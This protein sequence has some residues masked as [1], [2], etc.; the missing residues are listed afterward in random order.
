MVNI[1]LTRDV[2]GFQAAVGYAEK[3]SISAANVDTATRLCGAANVYIQAQLDAGV[4]N[5]A[6]IEHDTTAACVIASNSK[7]W[8]PNALVAER[9]IRFAEQGEQEVGLENSSSIS[10]MRDCMLAYRDWYWLSPSVAW[11]LS[12]SILA[13]AAKQM[14]PKERVCP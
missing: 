6:L 2:L 14:N 10:L 3:T 1:E 5:A 7:H 9:Y 8:K 4:S 13:F 12:C 11:V